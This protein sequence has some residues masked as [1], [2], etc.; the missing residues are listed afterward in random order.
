VPPGDPALR[1]DVTPLAHAVRALG[2]GAGA[3]QHI[4]GK[5]ATFAQLARAL[6]TIPAHVWAER[7]RPRLA[8]PE[9]AM[10]YLSLARLHGD[11]AL[12]QRARAF[13]L[14]LATGMDFDAEVP[15]FDLA[16]TLELLA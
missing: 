13:D 6:P 3:V 12:R 16:T 14:F 10:A 5:A 8:D 1:F 7:A 4:A 15:D 11:L 9:I 2:A